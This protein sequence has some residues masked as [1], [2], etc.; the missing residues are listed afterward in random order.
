MIVDFSLMISSIVFKSNF[1]SCFFSI[2]LE[3][4]YVGLAFFLSLL[5]EFNKFSFSN[6]NS[7]ISVY[8]FFSLFS[9]CSNN[10]YLFNERFWVSILISSITKLIMNFTNSFWLILSFSDIFNLLIHS[11]FT[12]A[13]ILSPLFYVSKNLSTS[14]LSFSKFKMPEL[15]L[16]LNIWLLIMIKYTSYIGFIWL[17]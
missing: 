7:S 12:R 4:Y 10:S 11:M 2:F 9:C 6:F 14:Y 8:I 13:F 17:C 5:S 3:V 15:N 16:Y 1:F